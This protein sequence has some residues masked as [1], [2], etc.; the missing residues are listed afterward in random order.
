M[1]AAA[2]MSLPERADQGRNYDYRYVWIRD[3]CFAGQ[4][5]ALHGH[6]SLLDAST[7]FVS[8]RLMEDGP[9][10]KPAYTAIGGPV[11]DERSMPQLAG[12]PG[13]ADKSGNWVNKQF[14][15]DAFGESLEL[16]AVASSHDRL[17]IGQWDAVETAVAAIEKRWTEPDAGIWELDDQRWA[18]SRLTCVSGLRAVAPEA[19]ATQS[20]RWSALADTILA[21]VSNDCLH[22]DGRWQ[23]SPSDSRVD[24]ALLLPI[25]RGAFPGGSAQRVHDRG[26]RA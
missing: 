25:I 19:P 10:L 14:Q 7:R 17:D 6:F 22:P 1:V 20:G 26:D 5:V 2:T 23:R 16:L 21:D 3:Q 13:G 15:L 11:P 8:E 4:A 9:Q 24:A 12:Y 18:H